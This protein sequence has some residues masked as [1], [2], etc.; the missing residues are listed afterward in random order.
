[1]FS[2]IISTYN[3]SNKI[4]NTIENIRE[5]IKKFTYEIIIIN[6]GSTDGTKELL[7]SY[8]NNNHFKI[9]NQNN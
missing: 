9:I 5:S 1:M 7:E 4:I 8:K 2:V 6:D 3:G